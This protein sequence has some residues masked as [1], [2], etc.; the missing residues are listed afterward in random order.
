MS[1]MKKVKMVDMKMSSKPKDKLVSS[2]GGGDY[3]YGLA[4]SLNKE[5]IK[6]LDL[7]PEDLV[8]GGEIEF[9]VVAKVTESAM[10]PGEKQITRCT[11]QIIKMGELEDMENE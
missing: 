6:K 1:K 10:E 4:I 7:E 5:S 9:K 2:I 3:P 11:M 8:V